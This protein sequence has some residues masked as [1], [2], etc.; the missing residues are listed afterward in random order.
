MHSRLKL[1]TSVVALG[2]VVCVENFVVVG[3]GQRIRVASAES[4]IAL[5]VGLESY[6]RETSEEL[7]LTVLAHDRYEVGEATALAVW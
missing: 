2:D 3:R 5:Q 7:S 6:E 1:T 4:E